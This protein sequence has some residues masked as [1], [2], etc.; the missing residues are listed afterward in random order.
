MDLESRS[1]FQCP[2]STLILKFKV[3][4]VQCLTFEGTLINHVIV[5]ILFYHKIVYKCRVGHSFQYVQAKLAC[6]WEKVQAKS[7]LY[8]PIF[9]LYLRKVT[10]Q[11]EMV[12]SS[13]CGCV[14]WQSHHM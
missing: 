14:Q 11:N 1:I 9:C 6:I 5:S 7:K 12:Q 4:Q 8:R 10:G 2:F 3:S 13:E